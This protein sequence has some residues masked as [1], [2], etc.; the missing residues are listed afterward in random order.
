[1][2]DLCMCS[3]R[4]WPDLD[5]DGSGHLLHPAAVSGIWRL[6]DFQEKVSSLADRPPKLKNL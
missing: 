4:S 5:R 3:S 1:M 2:V 6:C